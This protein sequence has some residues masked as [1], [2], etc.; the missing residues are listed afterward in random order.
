MNFTQKFIIVIALALMQ[1]A[2]ATIYYVDAD[3]SGANWYNETNF[4]F[5]LTTALSSASSGDTIFVAK[6]SYYPTSGA[7]RTLTFTLV[8]GV[9]MYG[10][11]TGGESSIDQRTPKINETILSGDIGTTDDNSDNSY[12]VVTASVAMTTTTVLD[13][14][15][16]ENGNANA[17]SPN[18]A[19]AGINLSGT[20]S[21]L[22]NNCIL[23]NNTATTSGG[24]TYLSIASTNPTFGNCLF[25]SNSA[26]NGGVI[27]GLKNISITITINKCTFV[28]NIASTD[29][30][31]IN[32]DNSNTANIDSCVF[33]N[34]TDGSSTINT[35][36]TKGSG[37]ANVSDSG[38]DGGVTGTNITAYATTP[39]RET[40]YYYLKST[41]TSGYGWIGSPLILDLKVFLEGGL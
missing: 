39:F 8:A 27:R 37:V 34:N 2:F 32:F 18:D 33:W 36:Y 10:G 11:F 30:S 9:K 4:S 35:I 5:V 40:T 16:I 28:D 1:F 25:K 20:A 6:G 17:A 38:A 29:G 23:R 3:T 24:V 19:G 13:G 41:D 22:I 26:A 12:H 15:V 21:P 14:F 31:I 7:D